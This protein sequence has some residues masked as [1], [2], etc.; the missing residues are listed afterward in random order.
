MRRRKTTTT[1]YKKKNG[2]TELVKPNL[3]QQQKIKTKHTY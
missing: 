3:K 2:N 1:T